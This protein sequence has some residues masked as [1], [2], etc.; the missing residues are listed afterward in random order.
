MPV[1]PTIVR[2]QLFANLLLLSVVALIEIPLPNLFP[3]MVYGTMDRL[4]YYHDN[5]GD[6]EDEYED[7][8]KK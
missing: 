7:V 8:K 5:Q 2:I 3:G 6:S 4:L 1:E